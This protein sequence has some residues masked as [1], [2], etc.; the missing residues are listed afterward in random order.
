MQIPVIRGK[1]ELRPLYERVP[2]YYLGGYVRWMCSPRRKPAPP[3]DVDIY[4]HDEIV[5]EELK[6]RIDREIRSE[7]DVCITYKLKDSDLHPPIQL[8]KPQIKGALVTAG[9]M[10]E[11]IENFDF[12]ICRIGLISLDEA[13]CDPDFLD[14]EAMRHLVPKNIHCPISSTLRAMKYSRKGYYLTTSSCMA[15]LDDWLLRSDSYRDKIR[16]LL[17]IKEPTKEEIEELEFL[18]RFD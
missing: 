14:D 8:I 11:I 10:A 6:Q 2:G 9:S 5:F 17:A 16:D 3:A 18:M 12:T 7:N 13:E 4:A 1:E 15:L